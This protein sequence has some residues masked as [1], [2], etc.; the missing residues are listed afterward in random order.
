MNVENTN[1]PQEVTHNK[2]S[3][4]N[5]KQIRSAKA[6]ISPWRTIPKQVTNIQHQLLT[7]HEVGNISLFSKYK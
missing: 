1:K 7:N 5:S 3:E 4:A 2:R 6:G